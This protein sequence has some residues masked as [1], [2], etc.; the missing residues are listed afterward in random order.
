MSLGTLATLLHKFVSAK[1][2]GGDATLVRPTNWNND[3]NFS[4]GADGQQL[5]FDSTQ[6]D[7][8]SWV[9]YFSASLTNQTG[10][11]AV[12]GDVVALSLNLDQTVV[13]DDTLGSLRQ[14][15]VALGGPATGAV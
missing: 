1:A 9:N 2:D 13:L 11:T 10:G 8:G 3:H 5:V 6:A 7:K 14:F 4:G 15:V 12:I